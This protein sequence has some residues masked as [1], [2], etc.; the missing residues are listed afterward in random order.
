MQRLTRKVSTSA[1]NCIG[2]F[3]FESTQPCLGMSMRAHVSYDTRQK[4]RID[5]HHKLHKQFADRGYIKILIHFYRVVIHFNRDFIDKIE[6]KTFCFLN[7]EAYLWN[8]PS[9]RKRSLVLHLRQSKVDA[10]CYGKGDHLLHRF[11]NKI[12]KRNKLP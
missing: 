12:F 2:L 7:K 4:F 11:E 8:K 1:W 9:F 3:R 10:T 5:Y 6:R